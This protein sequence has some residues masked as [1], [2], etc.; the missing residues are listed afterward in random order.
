VNYYEH[1][2]GDYAAATAHLSLVEDAVY[3]RMLRRYYLQE[4]P[5]PA[6][7]QQVAR[8]VG[9]RDAD[10]VAA[11]EAV[12]AEFFTLADDGWHQVRCDAEIARFREKQVAGAGKRDAE[13]ERQRR[14][15]ERRA[16]LFAQLREFDVVPAYDTPT[17]ELV[18]L[19]SRVTAGVRHADT[20]ATQSPD[21]R[22]QKEQEQKADARPAKRGTRLPTGW[23]PDPE[24]TE[25]ASTEHPLVDATK[26]TEKFRDYWAAK[27]GA[28]GC[29]LDWPAT[30]RNWIRNARPTGT[31]HAQ[32][33][34]STPES[35]A[36]R[37]ARKARE[38]DERER[39]RDGGLF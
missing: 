16:E 1:H 32:D 9:A 7:V 11:V 18:T 20:T 35:L 14:H 4:A 38:G 29:K 37:A 10:A 12:L 23:K 28:G 17:N 39:R 19:L 25:W 31:P 5:L 13:A 26:E 30:W 21:T 27:A 22:H 34:R 6:D 33:R 36:E 24:L 2:I 8:L 3:S 15:R